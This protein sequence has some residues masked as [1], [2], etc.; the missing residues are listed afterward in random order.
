MYKKPNASVDL[1]A[2]VVI[3]AE[4]TGFAFAAQDNTFQDIFSTELLKHGVNV[5]D[6]T[7]VSGLVEKAGG[8][9]SDIR[10]GIYNKI[11]EATP[12]RTVIVLNAEMVAQ[13]VSHASCRVLGADGGVLLSMNISN[14]APYQPIYIKNWSTE[15]I[16]EE[17]AEAISG[18]KLE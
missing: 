12:V 4:R 3:L 13:M 15:R 6:R 7:T 17:W 10:S 5:M 18:R 2:P 11:F 1:Q 16:A 9:L 8:S 14:P